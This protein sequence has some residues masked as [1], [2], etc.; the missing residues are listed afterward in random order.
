MDSN[1]IFLLDNLEKFSERMG[2]I[3]NKGYCV[4]IMLLL[5]VLY[6]VFVR[7]LNSKEVFANVFR[8]KR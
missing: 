4:A 2:L 6:Q 3:L 8:P 1:Q 5:S 7:Q